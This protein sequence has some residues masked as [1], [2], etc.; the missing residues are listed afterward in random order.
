MTDQRVFKGNLAILAALAIWTGW[1][2]MTRYA[3]RSEISGLSLTALRFLVAGVLMLP[4]AAWRLRMSLFSYRNFV[5]AGLMGVP[6]MALIT[7]GIK[8][9]A[10]A[11]TA[12]LLNGS[13]VFI[14]TVVGCLVLRSRLDKATM[15]GLILILIGSACQVGVYN[16]TFGHLAIVGAGTLWALY[17]IQ[18]QKWKIDA[19]DSIM[20]VSVLSLLFFAIPYI[21]LNF[22]A[23]VAIDSHTLL[24]QG[25]MQ[26][27][28]SSI[29]AQY[30]FAVAVKNI[31]AVNTSLF[32][33]LVP[34]LTG[35]I[36]F[37]ALDEVLS[38]PSWV[39]IVLVSLGILISK[40]KS[41][42]FR[43]LSCFPGRI[44]PFVSS[45]CFQFHK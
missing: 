25:L 34:V 22:Q 24:T 43:M 30:F 37:I 28:L 31:G 9:S 44:K 38:V 40:L 12:A 18:L 3:H 4:F 2:I 17:S 14:S 41:E 27:V 33:P 6:Y 8:Y 16:V 19:F 10:A 7:L 32:M 11:Q 5:I 26:G 45:Y 13:M 1:M 35:V 42:H 39:G 29:A 20:A 15:M 36:G 23:F 21:A